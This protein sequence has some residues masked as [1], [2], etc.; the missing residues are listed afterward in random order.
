MI[1]SIFKLSLAMMKTFAMHLMTGIARVKSYA[2]LALT[3]V[4]KLHHDVLAWP[5]FPL[6]LQVEAVLEQ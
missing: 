1:F 2:I 5:L 6:L 3:I 4:Y